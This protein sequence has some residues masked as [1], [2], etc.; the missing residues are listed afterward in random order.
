[1]QKRKVITSYTKFRD[2]MIRN[3]GGTAVTTMQGNPV[4]SSLEADIQA[5]GTALTAYTG[6]LAVAPTGGPYEH[7]LKNQ[8][9]AAVEK[10]LHQLAVKVNL[11]ADGDE[12]ILT[13]SGLP[14]ARVQNAAAKRGPLD[15]GTNLVV[16][17]G[18]DKGALVASVN[19]IPGALVYYFQYTKAPVTDESV[20]TSIHSPIP[21]VTVYGLN[22][23]DQYVFRVAGVGH[24]SN[25][26]FSDEVS[27]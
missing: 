10:A 24:D 26:V 27:S 9:R 18:P 11:L 7:T 1:M 14:L 4:F 13:Q 6:A 5:T 15:K 8:C 17:Q 12:A 19:K 3:I 23:R 20:W 22:R 2:E 16:K 21:S 25:L